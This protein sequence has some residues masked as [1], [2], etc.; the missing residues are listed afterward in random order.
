MIT[1]AT[2]GIGSACVDHVLADGL[3]RD[4]QRHVLVITGR[5]GPALDVRETAVALTEAGIRIVQVRGDLSDRTVAMQLGAA[6]EDEG[7]LHR[8]VHA[9]GILPST[10]N[11]RRIVEVDLVAAARVV[12]VMRPLAGAG[13]AAVLVSSIAAHRVSAGDCDIDAALD[14]PLDDALLERLAAAGERMTNPLAAYSWAKRGVLRLVAR[15]SR[16]WGDRGARICSVSPGILDT[17]VTHRQ[18]ERQPHMR[19]LIESTPLRRM[20]RPDEVARVIGFLLSD[21]A[22]FVTGSDILVDGGLVAAGLGPPVATVTPA[23]V[24]T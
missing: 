10:D 6:V 21:A 9:A 14:D 15:E 12:D 23:H 13:S 11:W 22:S 4:G 18:I 8:L 5:D 20:C 3:G 1:G 24:R 17:P 2:G 19:G 16:S 7:R